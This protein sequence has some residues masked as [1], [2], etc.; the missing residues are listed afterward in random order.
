M[1][2]LL[3]CSPF[4]KDA[5]D[6]MNFDQ[7]V[8]SLMERSGVPGLTLAQIENEE[9]SKVRVYGLANTATGAKVTDSQLFQAASLS[10]PVFAYITM[11]L[12]DQGLIGL[13][14]PLYT[15]LPNERLSNQ[16]YAEQLT[17]RLILS[18]Q[19]GLPNWGGTRLDFNREPGTRFG[20]SGE[21]YVYLQ[22]VL[23]ELTGLS[24]NALAER[25]LFE[26]LGM[27]SSYF[28]ID[29][30]LDV[31]RVNGHSI[32]GAPVA[33]RSFD[34]NA[35][36]SLHTTAE[37]YA[38]FILAVIKG[39]GLSDEAHVAML[40]KQLSGPA[41]S[42]FDVDE[43]G[44]SESIGWAL[45]WGTYQESVENIWYWHWG[46]NGDYRAFVALNPDTGDGL[47]YFSNSQHGHTIANDLMALMDFDATPLMNW[48]EYKQHDAPGYQS[49]REAK[50]AEAAHDY[51]EM[52]SLFHQ[53]VAEMDQADEGLSDTV[54]WYENEIPFLTA[55]HQSL[56]DERAAIYVGDYGVRDVSYDGEFL[57]YQ[58]DGGAKR[59]LI[60]AG[61][62][63][64]LLDGVGQF[65]FTF[66]V[67]GDDPATAILGHYSDG[68][69][70]RETRLRVR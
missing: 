6:E 48:L 10:K 9:V 41:R 11:R 69:S 34:E 63:R 4:E 33:L 22:N 28:A 50:V 64:F 54:A 62:H 23:T 30:K 29:R 57:H 58:R 40:E 43:P 7:S 27:T 39:I 70:D 20:Y 18:H 5:N 31:P 14:Q 15:L 38:T 16:D 19:S 21:G 12:V 47:V 60:P 49:W 68:S 36:S 46:D 45:G 56:S 17:A 53:A 66:E 37:D 32:A 8:L 61:E 52:M 35:A 67:E 42:A 2:T 1:V 51:N 3:A 13:D 65:H 26:P 44:L 59:R 24:L 25:E 55:E